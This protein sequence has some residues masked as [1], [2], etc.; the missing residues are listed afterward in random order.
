MI[1]EMGEC[2]P[3]NAPWWQDPFVAYRLP[4]Q[5][6]SAKSSK[7][8]SPKT[9]GLPVP[10][11]PQ[12]GKATWRE[13]GGLFVHQA[14]DVQSTV[15]PR[16]I[17]QM[18]AFELINRR[19][20]YSFQC[21]G[22]RT[23]GKAKTFEWVEFGFEVPPVLLNDNRTALYVNRALAFAGDCGA[24]ISSVFARHFGG[25]SRK[26]ERYATTRERMSASYWSALASE[27][28]EF[29]LQLG[30]QAAQQTVFERWLNTVIK[31]A[32]TEF[33]RAVETVG[34]DAADL[35]K[36]TEAEQECTMQLNAKRRK[37][38]PHE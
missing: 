4:A 36:R 28:R 6:K 22:L 32:R 23:D 18:T 16:F 11:R 19:S 21:V 24:I 33:E 15:R 12:E 35:R 13:F 30:E 2:R 1:F 26:S 20:T 17:E 14:T 31:T 29:I 7:A 8:A 10:I 3:E 38:M 5:K 9:K 34:D 37:E 27:F 25:K